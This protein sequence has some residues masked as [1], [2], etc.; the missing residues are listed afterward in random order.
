MPGKAA[1]GLIILYVKFLWC[2][3]SAVPVSISCFF[4]KLERKVCVNF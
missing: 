1:D 3:M 4:V 2:Q